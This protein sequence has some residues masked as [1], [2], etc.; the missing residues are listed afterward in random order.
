MTTPSRVT[1]SAAAVG[2]PT[3]AAMDLARRAL[4]APIVVTRFVSKGEAAETAPLG[5]RNTVY[6]TGGAG[7]HVVLPPLGINAAPKP[8]K[9]AAAALDLP[10]VRPAVAV[11]TFVPTP[12][13]AAGGV[14]LERREK[15]GVDGVP[16]IE[17]SATALH[18]APKTPCRRRA[19]GVI[20][21]LI[22]ADGLATRPITATLLERNEQEK[23]RPRSIAGRCLK[24]A[25]ACLHQPAF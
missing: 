1:R 7:R 10:A 9:A 25:T 24:D 17:A 18:A 23:T 22:S 2:K 11:P 6:A 15:A 20:A 19:R 21:E 3:V 13:K 14:R 12:R 16:S 4:V 5:L 8:H